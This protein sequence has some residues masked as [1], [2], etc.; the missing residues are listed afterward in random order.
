M[1]KIPSITLA[2][3]MTLGASALA[4]SQ[5]QTQMPALP[6]NR[7]HGAVGQ[8]RSCS[9]KW[10]AKQEKFRPV[11]ECFFLT[12]TFIELIG[13]CGPRTVQIDLNGF[14]MARVL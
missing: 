4:Q 13:R 2:V 11:Q 8:N 12:S 3:V 9:I 1:F 6:R 7:A 14:S 10:A 5:L